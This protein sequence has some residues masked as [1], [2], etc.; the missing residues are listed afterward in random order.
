M[1]KNRVDKPALSQ[2]SKNVMF[3]FS[4]LQNQRTGRRGLVPVQA[5]RWWGKEVG[6]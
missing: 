6:G 2:T 1:K 5:G 3:F 4:C